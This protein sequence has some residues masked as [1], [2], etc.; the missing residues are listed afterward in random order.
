MGI[1]WYYCGGM[2][3]YWGIG[4]YCGNGLEIG[5]DWMDL[6]WITQGVSGLLIS[7]VFFF[8]YYLKIEKTERLKTVI[9]LSS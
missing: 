5:G 1:G 4:C 3:L 9:D 2:P 8:Y 6:H 7:L